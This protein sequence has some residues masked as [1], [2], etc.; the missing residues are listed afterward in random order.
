MC[1]Y[2]GDGGT[3]GRSDPCHW[4]PTLRS[5]TSISAALT[6]ATRSGYNGTTMP[7]ALKTLRGAAHNEVLID[8]EHFLAALPWVVAAFVFVDCGSA[9]GQRLKQCEPLSTRKPRNGT[10]LS[11]HAAGETAHRRARHLR[12]AFLASFPALAATVPLLRYTGDEFER[13]DDQ[14]AEV[15][16]AK[17]ADAGNATRTLYTHASPHRGSEFCW[18]SVA[19]PPNPA[20]AAAAPSWNVTYLRVFKANAEG[21]CQQHGMR[22]SRMPS[23]FCHDGGGHSSASTFTFTFVRDPLQH[24]VSAYSEIVWR[25]QTKYQQAYQTCAKRG[26]YTFT[27]TGLSDAERARA[28]L[29]DFVNGRMHSPCC[30]QT[31]AIDLHALPQAAFVLAALD[32][33]LECMPKRV[34][35]IGKL[36]SLD[37]DWARIGETVGGF[38]AYNLSLAPKTHPKTSAQSGNAWRAAMDA[39][40]HNET[41]LGLGLRESFCRTL[42][43]DFACFDYLPTGV[44]ANVSPG[45]MEAG[46]ACPIVH[47]SGR[48]WV[49][50]R[51]GAPGDRHVGGLQT[52][53]QEKFE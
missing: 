27:S 6:G 12:A 52:R 46:R 11:D 15:A 30:P 38:G 41:S 35:L 26:C 42:R 50:T 24:F 16:S 53:K 39:L 32:G 18:R 1:A 7:S 2:P 47:E 25:M 44:C 33:R 45:V 3:G 20:A 9:V 28:F 48:G 51:G 40:L 43:H 10:T 22:R 34:D 8:G 37:G 14:H 4:S 23:A 29:H 5:Y 13:I 17:E 36:E 21:I 31:M 49:R 19:P